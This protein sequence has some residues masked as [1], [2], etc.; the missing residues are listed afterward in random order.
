M[1]RY[2]VAP[3]LERIAAGFHPAAPHERRYVTAYAA[4]RIGVERY[5]IYHAK[6]VGLDEHRADQWAIAAG[7]HPAEVWPNAWESSG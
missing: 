2:P 3:L 6:R 1:S 7:Y 4:R 5:A